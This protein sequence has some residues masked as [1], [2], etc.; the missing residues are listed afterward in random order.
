MAYSHRFTGVYNL[1]G[2]DTDSSIN[3]TANT[4]TLTGNLKVVGTTSNV[5]AV[6]TQLVDSVITLNQGED[7]AGVSYNY[8][9]RNASGIEIDRGTLTKVSLVWN[10][11]IGRWQL[12][13]DGSTYA[14]IVSG[15]NGITQVQDDTAPKL[16]GNLD[17]LSRTIFS[18]NNAVIKHDTNVAI[19]NTTV[20]PS[21]LSGYNIVYA[22]TPGSGGSGLYITNTTN[23]QQELV[24][25]TKAIVYALIM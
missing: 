3:I 22:Q 4:I 12:T 19:K 20:A 18:S 6:N 5:A 10:E 11:D 25:K 13:N 7:S 16:G 1:A 14:N 23:Q 15:T 8:N 21:T 17:V 24:T 9:G 2:V